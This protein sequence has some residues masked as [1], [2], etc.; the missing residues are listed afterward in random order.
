MFS[1]L[2]KIVSHIYTQADFNDDVKEYKKIK[3]SI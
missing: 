2:I 1:K 3:L